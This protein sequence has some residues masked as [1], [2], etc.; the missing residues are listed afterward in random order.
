MITK[1]D[2][3]THLYTEIINVISR[4]N[5]ALLTDAING[6]EGEAK[7]YLS[8]FDLEILFGKTGTNRDNVLVM[9]LK[10]IAV[11]H[12]IPVANPNIDIDYRETRY[13][14]AIKW[15]EKIQSGKIVPVGWVLAST[16][17]D[18][19]TDGAFLVSSAPKRET[20]F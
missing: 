13:N 12:F 16:T 7:G 18:T 19:I 10:D 2:F 5:D 4:D 11:W 8:R 15:L 1:E 14:N 17:D 9:Y 20:R 6:A 3:N